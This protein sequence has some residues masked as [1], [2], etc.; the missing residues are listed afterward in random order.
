MLNAES[1]LDNAANREA[2]TFMRDLIHKY[3][4]SPPNTYTD[5]K[6]EEVRMVFQSGN[7]LFERN[8]P[9]AYKLHQSE[10][11]PVKGKIGV[12][13]LPHFQNG[14]SVSTLGGWHV[15][16]SKYSRNKENAFRCIAYLMSS[17][18]QKQFATV[19]GWNPGRK[20][21]YD[22][23]LV[24]KSMPQAQ[25]LREVFDHA[26]ARPALPHYS[27]MSSALQRYLSAV[28]S[29][30]MEVKDA[31]GECEVELQGMMKQYA[32]GE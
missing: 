12:A 22:D 28:L 29:E 16:L 13:L 18:A 25:V 6:E 10:N 27:Y 26:V 23:S 20:D 2:A 21:V 8:W 17:D 9:Y 30:K 11:S 1:L 14:K 15:G 31:F 4:I 5:M 24:R 19:L 32:I 7:A 3:K